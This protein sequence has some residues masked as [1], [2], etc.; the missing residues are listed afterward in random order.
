LAVAAWNPQTPFQTGCFIAGISLPE[1]LVV[2][3]LA[4]F[5][6]FRRP[7]AKLL[8]ILKLISG[9]FLC[10]VAVFF[11]CSAFSK[12]PP[13]NAFP[14]VPPFQLGLSLGVLNPAVW[15][16]WMGYILQAQSAKKPKQSFGF[17]VLIGLAAALGNMTGMWGFVLGYH[18]LI[19]PHSAGVSTLLYL[20]AAF[21]LAVAGVLQWLRVF[22]FKVGRFKG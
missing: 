21:F 5:L 22:R 3:L 6:A 12:T 1:W 9:T 14:L 7:A 11:A 8:F 17:I 20:I 10:G 15:V 19:N 4:H 13:I 16:F 18:T 2:G